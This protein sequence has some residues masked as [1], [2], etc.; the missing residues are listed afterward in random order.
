MY[1]ISRRTLQKQGHVIEYKKTEYKYVLQDITN[2]NSMSHE[3]NNNRSRH[4][5]YNIRED[6]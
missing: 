1:F 2:F 4:F 6:I 5:H 3:K